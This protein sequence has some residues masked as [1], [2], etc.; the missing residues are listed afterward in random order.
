MPWWLRW[1]TDEASAWNVLAAAW[2]GLIWTISLRS[3][4]SWRKSSCFYPS[5]VLHTMDCS[6][7]SL[8]TFQAIFDF[9]SIY[10]VIIA[11]KYCVKKQNYVAFFITL[12]FVFLKKIIKSKI[13]IEIYMNQ[14]YESND[15]RSLVRRNW[16]SLTISVF[17]LYFSRF[18][19]NRYYVPFPLDMEIPF[20]IWLSS[21]A[22]LCTSMHIVWVSPISHIITKKHVSY[23]RYSNLMT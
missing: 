3:R 8:K 19:E 11:R 22:N 10:S 6:K 4:R 18:F 16:F 14:I 2:F 1:T 23:F 15:C 5:S 20:N 7:C 21:Y 13:S 12:S 9:E 17:V